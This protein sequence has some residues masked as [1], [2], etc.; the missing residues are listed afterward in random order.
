M[1]I[2]TDT[3]IIVISFGVLLIYLLSK[4][5]MYG[6]RN[7]VKHGEMGEMGDKEE[8][9]IFGR[10]EDCSLN[11]GCG[12]D[13]VV[14]NVDCRRGYCEKDMID[15]ENAGDAVKKANPVEC[16]AYMMGYDN[17]F[18][19]PYN[20]SINVNNPVSKFKYPSWIREIMLK[21]KKGYGFPG[22]LY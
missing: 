4:K 16:G 17:P 3:I 10:S 14:D 15:T 8:F 12:V 5:Y 22:N 19:Y 18:I 9:R 6:E 21:C 13:A 2:D 20:Y 7:G 11:E 1:D